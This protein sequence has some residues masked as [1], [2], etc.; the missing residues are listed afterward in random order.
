M[1]TKIPSQYF[2]FFQYHFLRES[3]ALYRDRQP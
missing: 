1:K 3:Y 2:Y